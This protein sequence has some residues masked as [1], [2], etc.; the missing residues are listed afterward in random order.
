MSI[1]FCRN[2]KKPCCQSVFRSLAPIFMSR[3]HLSTRPHL[4][5]PFPHMEELK[6]CLGDNRSAWT[7]TESEFFVNFK[8][9]YYCYFRKHPRNLVFYAI[10]FDQSDFT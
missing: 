1:Y 3:V 4:N 10:Y 5:L 6:N 9:P 2:V 7:N 8:L